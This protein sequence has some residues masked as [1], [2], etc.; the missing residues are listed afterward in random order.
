MAGAGNID[1]WIE[2][3]TNC[4][5]IKEQEVKELCNKAKEIL[6]LEENLV[7]VDA[8]VTVSD[9]L[10]IIH[11][12][13][14]DACIRNAIRRP[15][16][17]YNVVCFLR[18]AATSMVNSGI[19]LNS[20]RLGASARKRTIFSSEIMLIE[21]F[22]QSRHSCS[23]LHSKYFSNCFSKNSAR[24]EF[25]IASNPFLHASYLQTSN[26]RDLPL[27]NSAGCVH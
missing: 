3:L 19:C 13:Q 20:L 18:S 26:S 1:R 12:F 24:I 11:S 9:R 22:I 23:F 10:R 15:I 7:Q 17:S 16:S 2:Q 5:R 4:E 14:S 27:G 25:R 8:P 21:A 6:N